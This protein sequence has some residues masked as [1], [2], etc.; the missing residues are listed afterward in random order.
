MQDPRDIGDDVPLVDRAFAF[1]DLCG[2]TLY[3]ATYGEH[4]AIA[5]LV[6]FRTT[7]REISGPTWCRHR[8]VAR[9][10]RHARGN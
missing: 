6:M 7:V 8:E 2:F 4:A 5:V 9:R 10:R 1:I 3:T